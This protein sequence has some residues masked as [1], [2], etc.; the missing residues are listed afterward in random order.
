M[1]LKEEIVKKTATNEKER[2]LF[3]QDNALSQVDRNDGKST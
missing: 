3:H 1:C 2:M